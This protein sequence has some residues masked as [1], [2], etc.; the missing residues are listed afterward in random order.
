MSKIPLEDF[1]ELIKIHEINS[2]LVPGVIFLYGLNLI[3]SQLG[4]FISNSISIGSLI[5]FLFLSYGA[6]YLLQGFGNLIELY[7]IIPLFGNLKKVESTKEVEDEKIAVFK[8]SKK[9]C[10]GVASSFIFL[11]I[12]A[13]INR[14]FNPIS[15][16]SI[17]L[18]LLSII[19]F[20]YMRRFNK[21]ELGI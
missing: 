20:W 5:I 8:N 16:Y 14:T 12:F 21:R 15:V 11:L 6:G 13:L 19:L 4:N 17:L 1:K 10:R 9:I 18:L 2:I 3:Y 7:I